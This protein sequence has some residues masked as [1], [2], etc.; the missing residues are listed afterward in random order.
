MPL[1]N[2][3]AT[4]DLTARGVD[5]SATAL[6]DTMLAVASSLVREAAGSPIAETETTFSVGALDR[7][8]WFGLSECVRPVTAIDTVEVDGVAVTDYK[9]INGNLWQPSYWSDGYEPSELVIT[10]TVGLPVVP[11]YIT[12]LV[13]DLAILGINT[14]TVGAHDPSVIVEAIDD[15]SVT[16]S[17]GA[18]AVASAM[19][20][21]AL[22]RLGLR[23]KFGGGAGSV[24]F[25]S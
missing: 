4:S 11:A 10:A 8:Q 5:T 6:V 15:Y 13:C 16:F 22:T 25:V 9:L 19:T 2:L 20:V 17:S 12:Q 7:S 3:A 1:A 23:A 21:P 14:A 18:Q 24:R